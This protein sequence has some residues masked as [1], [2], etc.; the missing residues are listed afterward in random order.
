MMRTLASSLVTAALVVA[1]PCS[2]AAAGSA[3]RIVP[4]GELD[5]A[6]PDADVYKGTPAPPKIPD[7]PACKLA[8]H[9][10]QLIN[11]G[12]YADVAKLFADDATFLEPMRPTLQG[13]AEIDAFYTKRIG[14]MQPQVV[15]VRYFGEGPECVVELALQTQIAGQPRYVLVSIDHFTIGEDGKVRSMIAFARPMRS[16]AAKPG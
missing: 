3:P 6:L 4:G 10:V 1:A 14:G 2:N 15:A 16:A 9:Y 5:P 12:Q 11:A 13:R 7:E 8:A